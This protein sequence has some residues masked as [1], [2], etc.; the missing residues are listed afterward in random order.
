MSASFEGVVSCRL[1]L[2]VSTAFQGV[3]VSFVVNLTHREEQT[4]V[5]ELPS[6]NV[7]WESMRLFSWL[8]VLVEWP[9]QPL[10]VPCLGAGGKELNLTW[11]KVGKQYSSMVNASAPLWV[12]ALTS[13]S[14]G[15][16]LKASYR[17]N[18]FSSD[19]FLSRWFIIATECRLEY[20]GRG[21]EL[22]SAAEGP[23]MTWK[24]ITWEETCTELNSE[25]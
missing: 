2:S 15:L 1:L 9:R 8:L 4:S 12:S 14:E 23:F 5:E 17:I 21:K 10:V 22:Y 11:R 20:Q 13:H 25:N 3:L 6:A 18:F 7:L 19:F 24:H 16:L